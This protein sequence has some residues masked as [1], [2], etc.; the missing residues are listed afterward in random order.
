MPAISASF[1][2]ALASGIGDAPSTTAFFAR[3]F[4]SPPA[5]VFAFFAEE[6]ASAA[7][8]SAAA[9]SAAETFSGSTHSDFP[10]AASAL[11]SE[12]QASYFATST[13]S[14][15]NSARNSSETFDWST[16]R[17]AFFCVMSPYPS[18]TG[19]KSRS[20]PRTLN[21]HATSSRGDTTSASASFSAN[22][23]RHCAIFS[24]AVFPAHSAG[25]ARS[26]A[27][28]KGGRA[29]PHASSTGLVARHS[30]ATPCFAKTSRIARAS[31]R[32]CTDASTPT[33][34]PDGSFSASHC[35]GS[36]TL[37]WPPFMSVHSEESSCDACRK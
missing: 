8:S 37:G 12:T 25:C 2:I 9:T 13:P 34:A 28:G 21:S 19:L 3:V 20:L 27:V 1:L 31:F 6:G 5:S 33:F 22:A 29:S 18:A 11:T 16:Y 14:F 23:A 26:G 30:N 32:E 10:D 7:A 15:F 17:V 4:F 35:L 24:A 36:G